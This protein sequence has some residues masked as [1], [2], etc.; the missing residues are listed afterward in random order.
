MVKFAIIGLFS[1]WLDPSMFGLDYYQP[2]VVLVVVL[3]FIMGSLGLNNVGQSLRFSGSIGRFV[4]YSGVVHMGFIVVALCGGAFTAFTSITYSTLYLYVGVYAV[5]MATFFTFLFLFRYS[6][7][8]S[9]PIIMG[10]TFALLS[11]A[12]LPPFVGFFAKLAVFTILISSNTY[13]SLVVAVLGFLASTLTVANYLSLAKQPFIELSA[14]PFTTTTTTTS[15]TISYPMA[16]LASL[17]MLL[18]VLPCTFLLY[19]T[20]PYLTL[21]YPYRYLL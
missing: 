16:Y 8:H 15:S 12:G 5:T 7:G 9:L 1:M 4:G 17:F 18:L 21:P 14:G 19:F 10:L 6:N 2:L 11:L 20:L 3:S 13:L